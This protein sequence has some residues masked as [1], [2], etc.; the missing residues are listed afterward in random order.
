MDKTIKQLADEYGLS[1]QA[2]QYHVKKLPKTCWYFDTK[3]GSKTIMVKPEGQEYIHIQANKKQVNET[4]D[5]ATKFDTLE[6]QHKLNMAE[7]ENKNYKERLEVLEKQNKEQGQQ[8]DTLL[9]LVDQAQQLQAIA[10]QKIKLLEQKDE[11]PPIEEYKP[12]WW[13]FWK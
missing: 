7:L 2:I 4:V 12:K 3:Q 8:I 9:Q 6:L 5:F 11:E 13:H 10:E 1:K